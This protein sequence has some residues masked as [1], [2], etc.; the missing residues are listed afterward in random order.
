MS[1]IT[2][3]PTGLV[4]VTLP[5]GGSATIQLGGEVRAS[6]YDWH[7]PTDDTHPYWDPQ[8]TKPFVWAEDPVSGGIIRLHY[9]MA[10]APENMEVEIMN[11][12]VF[13]CRIQNCKLHH[14]NETGWKEEL[15]Y[16]AELAEQ[17]EADRIEELKLAA[18]L[19][20]LTEEERSRAK[21]ENEAKLAAAAADPA[22][23]VRSFTLTEQ[24]R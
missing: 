15:V 8:G 4:R 10:N 14:R 13:D 17:L 12:D 23:A 22:L 16:H 9:L 19:R 11:G 18:G 5:E 6:K 7:A 24:P 21:L 1:K 20:D 3:L 2:K